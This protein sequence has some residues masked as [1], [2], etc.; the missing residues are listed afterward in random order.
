MY[1]QEY[2]RDRSDILK[3]LGIKVI[4]FTNYEILNFLDTILI[5]I[6]SEIQKSFIEPK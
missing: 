3:E 4:R 2:D 1:S 6:I 5:Q